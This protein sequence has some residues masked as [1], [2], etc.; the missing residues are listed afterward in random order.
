M[1]ADRFEAG[2][3]FE[4]LILDLQSP[5]SGASTTYFAIEVAWNGLTFS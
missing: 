3:Q 5:T 4:L 2:T 1:P